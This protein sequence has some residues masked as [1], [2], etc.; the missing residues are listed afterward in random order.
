MA[1]H[2]SCRDKPAGSLCSSE[3]SPPSPVWP[4][5]W[6]NRVQAGPRWLDLCQAFPGQAGGPG[7]THE[8][9]E[10]GHVHD[11]QDAVAAVVGG[12]LLHLLAVVRVYFPPAGELA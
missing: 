9:V 3:A 11:V 8:E 2:V 6:Q 5:S 4:P 7:H 1:V 12:R 10:D